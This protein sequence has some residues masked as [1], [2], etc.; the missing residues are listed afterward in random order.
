MLGASYGGMTAT[1][2]GSIAALAWGIVLGQPSVAELGD[3]FLLTL[4]V[5]I[6]VVALTAGRAALGIGAIVGVACAA[7]EGGIAAGLE[8]ALVAGLGTAVGVA[9]RL[10]TWEAVGLALAFG[11]L[12]GGSAGLITWLVCTNRQRR[13]ASLQTASVYGMALVLIAGFVFALTG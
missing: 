9:L 7:V 11:G 13:S 8:W 2:V 4:L 12:S 10:A 6:P 1:I 5:L 3:S